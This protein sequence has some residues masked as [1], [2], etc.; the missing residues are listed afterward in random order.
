MS[1]TCNSSDT[2]RGFSVLQWNCNG[3]IAHQNELRRYLE[4]NANKH[5]NVFKKHFLNQEKIFQFQ[6]ISL[7]QDRLENN[8]GGLLTFECP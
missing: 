8:K 7:R 6:D 4:L 5:D 2:F 3:I 1:V